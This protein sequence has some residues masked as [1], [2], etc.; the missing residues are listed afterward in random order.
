M[1]VF[2][3]VLFA[4]LANPATASDYYKVQVTRKAQD[5]YQ[6]DFQSIYVKTRF[7]YEYVY[8]SEAIL[9]IDSQFE[10]NVGEIIFVGNG[11]AKYDLEK[12]L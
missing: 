10:Y 12:L 4:C 6:V 8:S 2:V 7:Y 9:R 5:L 11:G 1:R 3:A